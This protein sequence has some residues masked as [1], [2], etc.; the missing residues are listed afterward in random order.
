MGPNGKPLTGK[1]ELASGKMAHYVR[2]RRVMA[3][4]KGAG[5]G[6]RGGGGG[7]GGGRNTSDTTGKP[8]YNPGAGTTNRSQAA[9]DLANKR[10]AARREAMK[11]AGGKDD[12]PSY[13]KGQPGNRVISG[14]N[15]VGDIRSVPY[16]NRYRKE[17]WDGNKWVP[18]RFGK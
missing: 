12:N 18:V 14:K 15:K 13:K 9:I 10:L 3:G 11:K 2:G 8:T 1:V 7:G 5:G 16:R 6:S 17:K 4:G